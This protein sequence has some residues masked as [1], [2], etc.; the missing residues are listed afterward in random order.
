MIKFVSDIRTGRK[1]SGFPTNKTERYDITEI[2]LKVTLDAITNIPII[3]H[4]GL[5]NESLPLLQKNRQ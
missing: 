4:L 3:V 1:Y 2:L 5:M